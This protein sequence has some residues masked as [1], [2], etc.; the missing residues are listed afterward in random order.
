[1]RVRRA[2]F[3]FAVYEEIKERK[4][5]EN[6]ADHT[7]SKISQVGQSAFGPRIETRISQ[8]QIY[9]F[10]YLKFTVS[11]EKKPCSL[12]ASKGHASVF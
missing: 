12:A 6:T 4:K 3:T 2:Y 10:I 9:L 8:I 5:N 11:G 1:M 7:R